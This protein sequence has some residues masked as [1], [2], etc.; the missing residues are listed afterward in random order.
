M[1]ASARSDRNRL[2]ERFLNTGILVLL[3]FTP[4]AFGAVH[5]WAFSLMEM[6][7]FFL[8]LIWAGH[9]LWGRY[10]K[11]PVPASSL[12]CNVYAVLPFALFLCLAVFQLLPLPPG[13]LSTLSPATYQL[14]QTVLPGWPHQESFPDLGEVTVQRLA[15]A[16]ATP[17]EPGTEESLFPHPSSPWRPLSLYAPASRLELLKL[18]AY[19]AFFAL[20]A[21]KG[22]P[23]L[24]MF[25]LV[26]LGTGLALLAFLQQATWNGKLLWFFV[27]QH[28]SGPRPGNEGPLHGP[29]VNPDHFAGSL[30]MILPLAVAAML[31]CGRQVW[32]HQK[33]GRR[34]NF[35]LSAGITQTVATLSSPSAFFCGLC[36]LAT[37]VILT[38]LVFT[39]SRG[40]FSAAFASL[41]FM[42][43]L[44]WPRP[45]SS[46]LSPQSSSVWAK[47]G[48]VACILGFLSVPL[49]YLAQPQ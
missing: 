1:P 16:T 44:L 34:R 22:S 4:L 15:P 47:L 27:P 25:S 45:Q 39:M 7:I 19:S 24:I 35:S 42:A 5:V 21:S 49:L 12:S 17:S 26:T 40:G 28:W 48:R 9:T 23:L 43:W 32:Q 36:V 10:K 6:S 30:E 3:V 18:L 8:V 37:I 13:L 41:F 29:F 31:V 2:C 46:V 11:A 38:A 20:V 14:Y 33:I